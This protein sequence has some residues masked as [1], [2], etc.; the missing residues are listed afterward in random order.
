M[1]LLQ[2]LSRWYC[3]NPFARRYVKD[4]STPARLLHCRQL[5]VGVGVPVEICVEMERRHRFVGARRGNWR[6]CCICSADI[7]TTTWRE[8][9]IDVELRLTEISSGQEGGLIGGLLKEL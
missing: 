7:S 2:A 3:P 5:R 1:V 4:I 6:Q 9:D 8:V